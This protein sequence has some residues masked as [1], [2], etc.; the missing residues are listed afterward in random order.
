MKPESKNIEYKLTVSKSF[1]KTVSAFSN[2]NGG[3][4]IFG[5]TEDLKILGTKNAKQQAE[6]IEQLIG[7]SIS[8]IPEFDIV[9][10]DNHIIELSVYAG[11]NAPYYYHSKSYRR[12]NA[13]TVELDRVELQDFILRQSNTSY[14]ALRSRIQKLSFEILGNMLN[15][16]LNISAINDNVLKSLELMDIDNF[17]NNAACIVADKNNLYGVDIVKFG[18]NR[19]QFNNRKTIEHVSVFKKFDSVISMFHHYYRYELIE[20]VSRIEKF[21]IPK[22]AFREALANAL[23][24]RDWRINSHIRVSMFDEYIEITSPGS[25][26]KG[27]SEKEYLDS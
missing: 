17:Y 25:L 24:H 19:N 11:S 16:K 27:V 23:A 10:K 13:T 12:L 6:K 15:R 5:I 7:T 18:A 26:P 3:K 22:K 20:G 4:I 8:P 1:L 21:S 9:V 14:D 2:F